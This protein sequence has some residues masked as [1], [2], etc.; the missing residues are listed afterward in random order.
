MKSTCGNKKIHDCKHTLKL[1]S[2]LGDKMSFNLNFNFLSFL[3]SLF[4]MLCNKC[5]LW[6]KNCISPSFMKRLRLFTSTLRSFVNNQHLRTKHNFKVYEGPKIKIITK[7]L[8]FKHFENKSWIKWWNAI[9]SHS[10][11]LFKIFFCSKK[12]KINFFF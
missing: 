5:P 4:W 3:L 6:K 10:P 2:P 11:K 12:S 1:P 8:N 7:M 9:P